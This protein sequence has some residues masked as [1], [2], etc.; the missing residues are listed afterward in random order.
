MRN[1]LKKQ[2]MLISSVICLEALIWLDLYVFR[3]GLD[4]ME[5]FAY[6]IAIPITL[7]AVKFGNTKSI[8]M[9]GNLLF[10]FLWWYAVGG[11]EQ[12]FHLNLWIEKFLG[13]ELIF[14]TDFAAGMTEVFLKFWVFL[15]GIG[16]IIVKMVFSNN[17]GRKTN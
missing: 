3:L 2:A 13:V 10:V 8:Q 1:F 17:K 14:D 4:G 6:V 5:F 9:I 7:Y 15:I 12:Y 16:G 11:I